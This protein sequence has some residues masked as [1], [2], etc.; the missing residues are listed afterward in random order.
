MLNTYNVP[1]D[2]NRAPISQPGAFPGSFPT[3][4]DNKPSNVPGPMN[5]TRQTL[6]QA[7]DLTELDSKITTWL[8][9]ASQR[10]NEAPGSLTAQ[11]LE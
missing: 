9:A 4:S 1:P 7:K 8:A 3:A 5:N 10:E 6:A 11:Q 2:L